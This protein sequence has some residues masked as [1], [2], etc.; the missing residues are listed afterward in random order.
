MD[1]SMDKC[2]NKDT[3]KFKGTN[4]SITSEMKKISM[5]KAIN[6]TGNKTA[7]FAAAMLFGLIG[8]VFGLSGGLAELAG[9]TGD[10]PEA[11]FKSAWAYASAPNLEIYVA[12][13][14]PN[15]AEPGSNILLNI[16]INNAG[17]DISKDTTATLKA[18]YP[19]ALKTVQNDVSQKDICTGC[20]SIITYALSADSSAKSGSYPIEFEVM[21]GTGT[22][23]ISDKKTV[24]INV[25]GVPRIAFD[26]KVSGNSG[27]VTPKSEFEVEFDFKNIGTGTAK[28]VKISAPSQDFIISGGSPIIASLAAGESKKVPVKFAASPDIAPGVYSIPISMNYIDELGASKDSTSSF[29]VSVLG[30]SDII[31]KSVKIDPASVFPGDEFTVTARVQNVGYGDAKEVVIELD[32]PYSGYKKAFI[33]KLGKDEDAPAI[34]QLNADSGT[35][36][37]ALKIKYRDDFGEHEKTEAIRINVGKKSGNTLYYAAGIAVLLIAV[38]RKKLK[39]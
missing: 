23:R 17:T 14:S 26:A 36:D 2:M 7:V 18:A 6:K 33:G 1:K 11:P 21:H 12:N 25:V 39:L 5:N 29:G 19:F 20:S 10:L 15:P 35:S 37:A 16:I 30:N 24:D 32:S 9:L 3:D 31:V 27:K 22:S 38:F 28:D 8:G 4:K 13:I 34:F